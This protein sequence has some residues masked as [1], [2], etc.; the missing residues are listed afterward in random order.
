MLSIKDAFQMHQNIQGLNVDDAST[1]WIK[2]F[3]L[4]K[5]YAYGYLECLNS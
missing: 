4:H 1:S 2:V 5:Y 3:E